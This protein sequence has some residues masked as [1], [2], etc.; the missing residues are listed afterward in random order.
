MN[1]R[2][3]SLSHEEA[4]CLDRLRASFL[5]SQKLADQVRWLT[6]RGRMHL[7]REGHLIFHGCVPVDEQ[8]EFL[9]MAV[10]GRPYR[11]RALFEA[12]EREVYRL[13]ES[14]LGAPEEL[15]L[16]W[17]L[18]SG[19]QSPQSGKD[20]IT[21]FERDLVAD[22]RTHHE[23]KNPYFRLIHEAWFCDEILTE[24]GVDPAQGMIVNGYV[25]VRWKK[26][27]R[28]SRRAAKPLRLTV[29]SPKL[30]AITV[31]PWC[32]NRSARYRHP[33]QVRIRAGRY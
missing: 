30:M 25:P 20:R 10:A 16:F 8:A 9:P 13:V 31:S 21:T 3:R 7:V 1:D 24:F 27:S 11:G 18:R 14:P 15:D 4:A 6:A 28:P 33:S 19:P 12:I 2:L 29:R 23:T 5:A 17:Y 22:P 26:V 32:W